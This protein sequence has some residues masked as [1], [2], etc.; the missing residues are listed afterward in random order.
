[1]PELPELPEVPVEPGLLLLAVV[2]KVK[3]S[4]ALATVEVVDA[5]PT[6][7]MGK[8]MPLQVFSNTRRMVQTFFTN[9]ENCVKTHCTRGDSQR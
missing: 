1:M 4:K 8:E 2:E 9:A 3:E 7:T 6:V 5:P